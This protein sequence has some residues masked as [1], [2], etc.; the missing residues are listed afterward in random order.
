M[1]TQVVIRKNADIPDAWYSIELHVE[2]QSFTFRYESVDYADMEWYADM[3]TKAFAK[4]GIEVE[5]IR[6]RTKRA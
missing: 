3:L 1:K 5:A 2:Q 6:E 4:L